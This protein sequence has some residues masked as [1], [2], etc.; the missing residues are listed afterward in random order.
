MKRICAHIS[1]HM[2]LMHNYLQTYYMLASVRAHMTRAARIQQTSNPPRFI[3]LI[4][5][6]LTLCR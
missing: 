4:M 1:M 3:V 5:Q 6:G 2:Y